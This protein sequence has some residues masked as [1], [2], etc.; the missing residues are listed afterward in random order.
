M[1]KKT[2]H[3]LNIFWLFSRL[4]IFLVLYI[5]NTNMESQV[6][7]S[8]LY[9][10]KANILQRTQSVLINIMAYFSKQEMINLFNHKPT[11]FSNTV[12][13]FFTCTARSLLFAATTAWTEAIVCT[14]LGGM[15]SAAVPELVTSHFVLRFLLVSSPMKKAN[16]Y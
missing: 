11:Y 12:H 13:V 4:W 6:P 1:D 2:K 5:F 14:A 3:T 9:C 16:I 10:T 7:L 8:F 15:V